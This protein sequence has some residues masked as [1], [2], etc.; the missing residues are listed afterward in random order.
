MRHDEAGSR[1]AN[2]SARAPPRT[3][4]ERGG[5]DLLVGRTR[6]ARMSFGLG[7]SWPRKFGQ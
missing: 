3:G 4:R 2:A 6:R 7:E 5:G 1:L